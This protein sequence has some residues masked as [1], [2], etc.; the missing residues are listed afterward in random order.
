M[1]I[2][3]IVSTRL[4]MLVLSIFLKINEKTTFERLDSGGRGALAEILF[5]ES[6]EYVSSSILVSI[7]VISRVASR[8]P[9]HFVD[10]WPIAPKGIK[11]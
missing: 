1:P 9:N 6:N 11:T 4:L 3:S 5:Q 2:L 8:I 10:S 7:F